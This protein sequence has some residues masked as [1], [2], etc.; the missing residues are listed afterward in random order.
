MRSVVGADVWKDRDHKITLPMTQYAKP[1]SLPWEK[2][3]RT[4]PLV[5]KRGI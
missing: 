5:L 1:V 4:R 3:H 2:L